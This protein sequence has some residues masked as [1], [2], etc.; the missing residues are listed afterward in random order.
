MPRGWKTF[1]SETESRQQQQQQQF[2]VCFKALQGWQ[3][4]TLISI[5][6]YKMYHFEN[7]GTVA[8]GIEREQ[9]DLIC[10]IIQ[11]TEHSRG[12]NCTHPA[13]PPLTIKYTFKAWHVTQTQKKSTLLS[14]SDQCSWLLIEWHHGKAS[15]WSERLF[16]SFPLW[17]LLQLSASLRGWT[18]AVL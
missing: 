4:S 3:W 16:P 12:G 18:T 11:C 5:Y 1:V 10:D 15:S 8:E 14:L 9:W 7:A 2:P 13:V 17:L 6:I